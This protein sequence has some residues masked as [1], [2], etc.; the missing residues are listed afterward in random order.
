MSEMADLRAQI[1]ALQNQLIEW[2][3]DWAKTRNATKVVADIPVP[4]MSI[5][6]WKCRKCAL[7]LAT[8]SVEGRHAPT[9]ASAGHDTRCPGKTA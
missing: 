7:V 1:L 3:H 6:E 8:R 2:S 9:P 4:D 5:A